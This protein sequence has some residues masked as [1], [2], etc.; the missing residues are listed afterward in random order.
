[1]PWKRETPEERARSEKTAALD[2]LVSSRIGILIGPA[3]TGKTTVIQLL[4]TRTDIVGTRVR[5]LAQTGKAR[6]RLGQETGQAGNVQT[7]AQFLL[8]TRF[9]PDTGRYY[10]NPEAPKTEATTCIIDECSMLTED[11]ARRCRPSHKKLAPILYRYPALDDFS[12]FYRRAYKGQEPAKSRISEAEQK[13]TVGD[14]I[15][16]VLKRDSTSTLPE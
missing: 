10:T 1:M 3:G 13:P 11:M 7:V 12:G 16:P 6:V 2:R 8:G 14:S 5:L 4:L 15:E 9:D